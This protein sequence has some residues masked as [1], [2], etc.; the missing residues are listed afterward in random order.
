MVL[1]HKTSMLE[2]LHRYAGT[3]VHPLQQLV[4]VPSS[5]IQELTLGFNDEQDLRTEN[6]KLRA[7]ND[8]LSARLQEFLAIR[9]E[10]DQL[11]TLLDS[12][13]RP[14]NE[15][16]SARLLAVSLNPFQQR[17]ILD[18]GESD[19]VSAGITIVDHNGVMGQIT[20]TY[21]FHSE[22][23]LASDPN[24]AIPV[25]SLRTGDRGIVVGTGDPN[26]F[27]LLNIPQ[28]ADLVPGDRFVTSGIAGR[29]PPDYPV[30]T[31]TNVSKQSGLPFLAVS[32]KPLAAL[33]RSKTV[34][35]IRGV[36]RTSPTP[37]NDSLPG[38]TDKEDK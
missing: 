21:P 24:H 12:S 37:S 28:T 10:N 15:V 22:G 25:Q 7:Q 4:D 16:T 31:V 27:K 19:G 23:I 36:P 1:D 32:A 30:A 34:L 38:T 13:I 14:E 3:L 2:G 26:T 11:R 33:S 17:V 35:L 9:E 5:K 29:F 8:M 18:K 20:R 6:L